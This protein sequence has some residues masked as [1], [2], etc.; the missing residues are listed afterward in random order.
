MLPHLESVNFA[1]RALLGSSAW[2]AMVYQ[3]GAAQYAMLV[4]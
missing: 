3:Q 1:A 2:R 4:L